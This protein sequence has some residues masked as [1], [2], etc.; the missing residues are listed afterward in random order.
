VLF[1]PFS[2]YRPQLLKLFFSEEIGKQGGTQIAFTGGGE[3][4][5]NIFVGEGFIFLQLQRRGNGSTG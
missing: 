1:S 3:D 4:H 2:D 5:H